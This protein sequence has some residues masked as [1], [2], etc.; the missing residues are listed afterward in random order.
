MTRIATTEHRACPQCN[1]CMD[2]LVCRC[3]EEEEA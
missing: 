2:C 3:D 1:E